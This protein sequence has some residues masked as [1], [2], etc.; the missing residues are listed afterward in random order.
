MF[1]IA[2]QFV[3]GSLL[4]SDEQIIQAQ[5]FLW[6][7]LRVIAEPGG[8]TAMAALLAGVY[9]PRAG[10]SVGV[11]VCGANAELSSFPA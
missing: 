2:R 5:T 8:A 1:P 3:A 10:E 11:V 7:R 9:R 4:V 6:R